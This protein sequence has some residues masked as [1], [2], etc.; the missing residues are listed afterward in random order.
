[1]EKIFKIADRSCN[2]SELTVNEIDTFLR[3]SPY[4][5]FSTWL[6]VDRQ[7]NFKRFDK[8]KSSSISQDELAEAF[9]EY[10]SSKPDGQSKVRR[11]KLKLP[12]T[13]KQQWQ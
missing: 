13:R 6:T 7:R 10:V 5:G 2:N 4:E 3:G 9:Q 8:N 12:K 1:M 11:P